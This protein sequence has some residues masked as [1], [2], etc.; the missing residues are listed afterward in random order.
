MT[1]GIKERDKER[2]QGQSLH[3]GNTIC[4]K[5]RAIDSTKK[6]HG[7]FFHGMEHLK[8]KKNTPRRKWEE[9]K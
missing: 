5:E 3:F 4:Q 7:N 2:G 1:V 6:D 8:K 9:E